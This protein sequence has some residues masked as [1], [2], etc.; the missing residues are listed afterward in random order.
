MAARTHALHG[1]SAGAGAGFG[2]G[3][4]GTLGCATGGLGCTGAGAGG[5]GLALGCVGAGETGAGA[6]GAG[7]GGLVA[8]GDAGTDGLLLA[9]LVEPA[10]LGGLAGFELLVGVG[11]LGSGSGSGARVGSSVAAWL[12]VSGGD[13]LL[14]VSLLGDGARATG[15]GASPPPRLL[16][17]ATTPMAISSTAPTPDSP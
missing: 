5:V 15:A 10:G 2:A 4:A 3:C 1:S 9:G 11:V 14:G 8:A 13:S 16:V 12:G 6:L 7:A 17:S